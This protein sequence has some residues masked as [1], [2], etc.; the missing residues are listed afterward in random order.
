MFATES[1]VDQVFA[2]VRKSNY[3]LI[4]T[5]SS[6][7]R[8]MLRHYIMGDLTLRILNHANCPVLVA[9]AGA[10]AGPSRVL[11]F[12]STG[13]RS[14]LLILGSGR[15]GDL[16]DRR[17]PRRR[18]LPFLSTSDYNSRSCSIEISRRITP[19]RLG[20][21]PRRTLSVSRR[22]AGFDSAF[23]HKNDFIRHIAAKFFRHR[24]ID[25]ERGEV[26]IV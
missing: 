9:R 18:E 1:F 7:A 6:Q 14:Q 2:E 13:L 25:I 16:A 19:R 8:G 10:V 21:H 24:K 3:D 11:A 20:S 5:G 23:A 4:V 22:L 12:R 15:R 17:R 26:A